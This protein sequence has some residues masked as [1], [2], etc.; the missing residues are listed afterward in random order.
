MSVLEHMACRVARVCAQVE[1][2]VMNPPH[3]VLFADVD[4]SFL[5]AAA[6]A[7]ST[8]ARN[9]VR[10]DALSL[11]LCSSMTRAELEMCQQELEIRHPF[12]CE[13]GAAVFVPRD[14]FPF[15]LSSDR[16]VAGYQVIEFGRRHVEVLEMLHRAAA[17]AHVAV[18]GFTELSVEQV[19]TDCGLSLSQARLSKLREYDE[20]IRPVD[21]PSHDRFCRA[22]SSAGLTFTCRRGYDHVGAAVDKGK[23]VGLLTT[24][25]RR[26][27][28]SVLTIGIGEAT[29]GA[30]LLHRV[31]FPFVV[32]RTADESVRPLRGV[33]RLQLESGSTGWLDT[34]AAGAQQALDRQSRGLQA[35][36]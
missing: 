19:A 24:L 26:A 7:G 3:V 18:V 32:A 25:Y 13:S 11:V 1:P 20:P 30:A 9:V 34:I 14:Y 8:A 22:L 23:C 36:R 35:A 21:A 5:K 33:P 29:P 6:E 10:S 27:F 2:E 17:R 12:I 4:H 15:E 28:G 31:K 16:E